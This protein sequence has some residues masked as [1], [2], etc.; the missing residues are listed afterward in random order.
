MRMREN[1]LSPQRRLFSLS[2][3]FTRSSLKSVITHADSQ[4]ISKQDYHPVNHTLPDGVMTCNV[5]LR[6][7]YTFHRAAS[8]A[9]RLLSQVSRVISLRGIYAR[10]FPTRTIF[11]EPNTHRTQLSIAIKCAMIFRYI[12]DTSFLLRVNI[13]FNQ[14]CI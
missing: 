9:L 12:K 5:I 6:S 2:Y 13:F 10:R 1:I 8:A 7:L 4:R 14:P 3:I 11:V